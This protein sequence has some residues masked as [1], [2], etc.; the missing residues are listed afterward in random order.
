[1]GFNNQDLIKQIMKIREDGMTQEEIAA[2]DAKK[3]DEEEQKR[4]GTFKRK[5]TVMKDDDEEEEAKR[6][7]Q[8]MD[9]SMKHYR[10]FF[11]DELE[12]NKDIFK[13]MP[14]YSFDIWR[15]QSRG[16]KK[17]SWFGSS[18]DVDE[19]GEA[20]TLTKAGYFKGSIDVINQEDSDAFEQERDGAVDR[21]IR[22]L[23]DVALKKGEPF[24]F[25]LNL[26]EKLETK[27]VFA[28]VL[29]NIDCDFDELLEFLTEI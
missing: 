12:N 20:S 21:I 11:D 18:A 10:S 24:D 8:I 27:N 14:F 13:R 9:M 4:A 25:K 15:G 16:A 22:L 29:D 3:K 6:E 5:T 7:A 17:S 19:S 28:A 2:K 23:K 1:M 26:L